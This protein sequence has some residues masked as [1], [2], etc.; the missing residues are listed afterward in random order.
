[1]EKSKIVE[2]LGHFYNHNLAKA[3]S[4][5]DF[6]DFSLSL[7]CED[8]L[9]YSLAEKI[10][11]SII[12]NLSDQDLIDLGMGFA[13]YDSYDLTANFV[14]HNTMLLT[15][16]SI[17]LYQDKASESD[18]EYLAYY[19]DYRRGYINID[20]MTYEAKLYDLIYHTLNFIL[21]LYKKI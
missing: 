17:L 12:C 14:D 19:L 11:D 1:M 5:D 21:D 8:N 9:F 4:F 13:F 7:K 18:I 2:L 10:S 15:V 3:L 16:V 20:Y 6:V